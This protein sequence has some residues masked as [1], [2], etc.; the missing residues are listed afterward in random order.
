MMDPSQWD[1][2]LV[3]DRFFSRGR[4]TRAIVQAAMEGGVSVV[5]LREKELCTRDFYDAGLEIRELLRRAGI[6]LIIN[7]RIDI[8]LALDADGVHIGTSDMPIAAARKILGPDKIIG[9]SVNRVEDLDDPAASLADYLA[10][11]PVFPTQT[12]K[13]TAPAWGL[14]GLETA[15]RTTDKPLVAIGGI[16]HTNAA[17]VIAAGAD[18]IAVVTAIVA[19]DD[20]AEATKTLKAIV[21]K[22][23]N[24]R[25]T[26]SY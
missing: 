3:T 24:R 5:Q 8:A 1:V 18:C 16:S 9:L 7:D 14:S 4:S 15:R 11:S 19:A 10:V 12:K 21:K 20:P 22:E 26:I 2:Y 23:K 13:D 25:G 6:P 17:S